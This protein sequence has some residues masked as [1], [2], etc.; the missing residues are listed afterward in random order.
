[1]HEVD[2]VNARCII[3][4]I[5]DTRTIETDKS[6][7]LVKEL[8]HREEHSCI[9]DVIEKDEKLAISK[10]I[11]YAVSNK[12]TDIILITGGTGISNRDI[13]IEVEEVKIEKEITGLGE[14]YRMFIY[15]VV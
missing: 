6:G 14:V 10:Q 1:M 8:L 15:T 12:E 4:T 11:D 7:K 9:D 2:P 13:T 5:S 3:I